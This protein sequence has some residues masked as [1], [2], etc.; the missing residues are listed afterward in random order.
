MPNMDG[1]TPVRNLRQMGDS[2]ADPLLTT[3][4]GFDEAVG[5][6]AG[7]T[8]WLVAPLIP[9]RCSMVQ[10]VPRDCI[11]GRNCRLPPAFMPSDLNRFIANSSTRRAST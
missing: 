5:A 8:G 6:A 10:K 4:L 1:L 3:E 9:P 11:S 2:C 7:A